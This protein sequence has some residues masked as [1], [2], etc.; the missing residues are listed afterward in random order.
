MK[1][2]GGLDS[3]TCDYC[4]LGKLTINEVRQWLL[5][6]SRRAAC[7]PG[8]SV[9]LPGWMPLA[10][11]I[12]G[13][14]WAACPLNFHPHYRHQSWL[15]LAPLITEHTCAARRLQPFSSSLLSTVM[16]KV[17][18]LWL[19][20]LLGTVVLPADC[21]NFN[22]HYLHQSWLPLASLIVENTYNQPLLPA[23]HC[24]KFDL[25]CHHHFANTLDCWLLLLWL[26]GNGYTGNL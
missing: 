15:P 5:T 23:G 8:S 21:N 2:E 19:L 22:P 17:D 1:Y 12:A 4:G 11:L 6:G 7:G 3:P 16:I 13:H 24:N 26:L 14:T 18:C 25:H 9:R 20:R 10:P